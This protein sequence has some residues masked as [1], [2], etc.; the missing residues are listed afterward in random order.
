MGLWPGDSLGIWSQSGANTKSD[1]YEQTL[2]NLLQPKD[3]GSSAC[4][5]VTRKHRRLLG[6][7]LDERMYRTASILCAMGAA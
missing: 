1:C 7:S 3:I 4:I 2:S 5:S 6:A